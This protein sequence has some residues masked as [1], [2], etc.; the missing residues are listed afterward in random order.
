[1]PRIFIL[2][3]AVLLCLP[4]AVWAEG[5]FGVVDF[6]PDGD[7]VVLEN[8]EVV[9]MIGIDAPETGRDGRPD[10]YFADESRDALKSLTLGERV[11]VRFVGQKRRDRH[12]RL[13][14]AVL[15]PDG[16]NANELQLLGGYAYYYHFDDHPGWL[17][18]TYMGLQRSAIRNGAGFWPKI[19]RLP[20]AGKSWVGYPNR[21][22]EPARG[23][24][25]GAEKSGLEWFDNLEQAVRSGYAP[26]RKYSPWSGVL[27][28]SPE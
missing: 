26:V 17:E 12:G 3:T 28:R 23:C 7:T 8:G 18:S 21:R 10:Q 25:V 22:A 9:R 6:V 20:V 15:M 11:E 14:G 5:V 24:R 27:D 1:M 16:R 13:L 19:L 4:C 2:L